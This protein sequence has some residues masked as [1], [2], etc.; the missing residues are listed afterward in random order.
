MR[1]LKLTLATLLLVSSYAANA[2]PIVVWDQSPDAIGGT[3][4]SGNWTN[5][6]NRE[7]LGQ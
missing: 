3:L 6:F 5:R 1:Y 4:T 2:V 7:I